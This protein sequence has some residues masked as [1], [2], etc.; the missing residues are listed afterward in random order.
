[1]DEFT[2]RFRRCGVFLQR[3]AIWMGATN[4]GVERTGKPAESLLY[5][6]I[7]AFAGNQN[8]PALQQ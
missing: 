8:L 1:M 5:W 6:G 2:M 7:A 3:G 4:R